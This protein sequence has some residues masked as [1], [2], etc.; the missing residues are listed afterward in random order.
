MVYLGEEVAD[1]MGVL[2]AARGVGS[3]LEERGSGARSREDQR[4]GRARGREEERCG[5]CVWRRR[6]A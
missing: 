2:G 1:E 4:D 6:G 5:G 3:W